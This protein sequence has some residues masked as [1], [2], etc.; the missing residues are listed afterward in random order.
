MGEMRSHTI[1]H[2][3]VCLGMALAHFDPAIY[4]PTPRFL[5]LPQVLGDLELIDQG[6][7]DHK[8]LTLALTLTLAPSL[9]LTLT[10]PLPLPL[11]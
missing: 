6:G 5:P 2:A 8:I 3:I 10:L 11:T 9:A 4:R 1:S 7:L